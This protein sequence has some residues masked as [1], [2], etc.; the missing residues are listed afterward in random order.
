LILVCERCG[1]VAEL[2]GGA[3]FEALETALAGAG[4]SPRRIVTEVAGVCTTCRR[5]S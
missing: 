1:R 3:V 5:S 4:F 2:E